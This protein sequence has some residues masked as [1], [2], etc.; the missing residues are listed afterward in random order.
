MTINISQVQRL[1]KALGHSPG[2]IDGIWGSNSQKALDSACKK[3]GAV[4]PVETTSDAEFWAGVRYFTREEFRCHCGGKYC[5][6]F[7]VEP[8]RNLVRKLDEL[9][10]QVGAPIRISSGIRCAKHNANVEG[11][12]KASQH[13]YGTAADLIC[14]NLTPSKMLALAEKLLPGTGG[15][16][17]YSWGIHFDV[18]KSKARWKG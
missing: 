10:A 17:L 9:R 5:N 12:A 11:S 2:A 7:P 4:D 15:L 6:G 14:S 1:L 8:D 16:G 3:Y 18:R 13:M